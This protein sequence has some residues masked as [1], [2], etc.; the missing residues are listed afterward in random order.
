MK[1]G[2]IELQSLVHLLSQLD[3]VA[4]KVLTI[5]VSSISY[6]DFVRTTSTSTSD[7]VRYKVRVWGVGVPTI[8]NC[9]HR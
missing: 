6:S 3:M 4:Y 7:I 8:Q 5:K 2:V 9:N 1:L